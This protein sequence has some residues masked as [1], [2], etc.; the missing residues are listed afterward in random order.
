[1]NGG[2]KWKAV[3][4]GNGARQLRKALMEGNSPYLTIWHIWSISTI[5]E[6]ADLKYDQGGSA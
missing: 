5:T 3:I 4:E 6:C 1:M 2:W